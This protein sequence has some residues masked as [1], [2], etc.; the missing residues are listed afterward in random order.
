MR[1]PRGSAIAAAASDYAAFLARVA[2][3]GALNLPAHPPGYRDE[4]WYAMTLG[5]IPPMILGLFAYPY[6]GK[7][8]LTGA[9]K[10]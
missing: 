9:V 10:G 7:S 3:G 1:R 8:M 2:G 6:I 5:I 4:R